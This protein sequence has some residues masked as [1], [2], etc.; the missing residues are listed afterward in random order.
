MKC[1]IR[2]T[3]KRLKLLVHHSLYSSKNS[4]HSLLAVPFEY[5]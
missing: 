4:V 3:G 2:E 1:A 5:A